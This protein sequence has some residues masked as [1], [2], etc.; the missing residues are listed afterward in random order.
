[1]ADGEHIVEVQEVEI[2]A[3]VPTKD[4]DL[5][6]DFDAENRLDHG[7]PLVS[8]GTDDDNLNDHLNDDW[9]NQDDDESDNVSVFPSSAPD[10]MLETGRDLSKKRKQSPSPSSKD[11]SDWFMSNSNC[12]LIANNSSLTHSDS[13]FHNSNFVTNN[14]GTSNNSSGS[15]NRA[16]NNNL[17]IHNKKSFKRN[18]V[19]TTLLQQPTHLESKMVNSSNLLE[20]RTPTRWKEKSVQIKTLGGGHFSFMT[21]VSANDDEEIVTA[22]SLDDD[23]LTSSSSQQSQPQLDISEYMTGIKKIPKEGLPGVDLSDPKQ[24]AEFAKMKPRKPSSD[25]DTRTIGCPHKGCSKMFRDNSAMRKHLHTHGPR[26]HVCAE[27]GKAFVESSKLKRHQLVHTGEKPFQCTFEGCGKRFSLDFNL[28]THVR[29][30][31]GDRPYVCPFD[32]CSKKFAQSTNLKSHI[33]THAKAKANQQQRITTM[34][35][36]I[37]SPTS[38]VSTSMTPDVGTECFVIAA[39][40]LLN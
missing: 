2:E 11:A 15:Y 6:D 5:D 31:T 22:A 12:D 32:G 9:S 4:E 35:I 28:R 27:C 39:P 29:I 7:E 18:L 38:S 14:T 33:L 1:M 37:S 13:L 21:W 26:V 34:E 16:H 30:H 40:N 19:G 8:L 17:M 10:L 24:L 36:P 25:D 3:V 23:N 20:R